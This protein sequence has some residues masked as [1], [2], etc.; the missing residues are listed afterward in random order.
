M[1]KENIYYKYSQYGWRARIGLLAPSSNIT[2][3]P[4]FNLMAPEGVSIHVSRLKV[5]KS[6]SSDD[7]I[8]DMKSIEQAAQL[9]KMIDSAV[10]VFGCT[11][12]S[13]MESEE[14]IIKKIEAETNVQAITSSGAILNAL[15]ALKV[16]KLALA[17]PYLDF[18]NEKEKEWLESNGYEVLESCGLG[19]G[20]N[21]S[22]IKLTG[23]QSAQIA[24]ELA[25]MVARSNPEAIFISCGNFATAPIIDY[26][27]KDFSVPVVTSSQASFWYAIRRAGLNLSLEGYGVLMKNL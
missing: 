22:E 11:S 7:T 16:Q 13:F 9:L 2:L 5:A 20:K 3:E 19:L 24:Y 4:E 6:Y 25:A 21:E 1:E 18:I 15:K 14:E 26:L 10:I 8:I 12:S 17:T 23:R 27:E